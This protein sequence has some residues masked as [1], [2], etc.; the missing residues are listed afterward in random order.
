MKRFGN[1]DW[2]TRIEIPSLGNVTLKYISGG[3]VQKLIELNVDNLY[4]ESEEVKADR[5][6]PLDDKEYTLRVLYNQLLEP[7]V[8]YEQF[9]NLDKSEIERMGKAFIEN[10]D[11]FQNAYTDTGDFYNDFRNAVE[12]TLESHIERMKET[13]GSTMR[14]AAKVFSKLK[15][16]LPKF[17]PDKTR[18]HQI[19]HIQLGPSSD[20]IQEQNEWERHS[21]TLELLD[22]ILDRQD[23]MKKN[24]KV[25]TLLTI[26]I[27][28][29]ST[30]TLIITLVAAHS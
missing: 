24:Q 2:N 29:V 27:L 16:Q 20:V 5:K 14:Q 15:D 19:P 30:G 13:A 3:D 12:A 10:E 9:K 23:T 26:L 7:E 4:L 6:E 17:T 1:D 28:I 22:A 21:Q 18:S 8:A 11:S 25:D